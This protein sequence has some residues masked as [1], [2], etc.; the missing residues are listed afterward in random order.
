[1]Q[2]GEMAAQIGQLELGAVG[3]P[4]TDEM[5]A[6]A[7]ADAYGQSNPDREKSSGVVERY[8]DKTQLSVFDG[9]KTN[10]TEMDAMVAYLQV[11][12]ELTNA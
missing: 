12:G 6:N 7:D 1:P 3:V 10:V 5:I 8:G 9:V 4:Y 2:R 11:L